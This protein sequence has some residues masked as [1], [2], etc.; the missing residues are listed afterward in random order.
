MIFIV[1]FVT[2]IV[3]IIKILLVVEINSNNNKAFDLFKQIAV[4]RTLDKSIICKNQIPK[5]NNKILD[6]NLKIVL[7]I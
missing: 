1:I 2:T 7:F 4:M 6:Q 5:H 3:I